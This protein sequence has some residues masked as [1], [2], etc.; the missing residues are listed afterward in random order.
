MNLF[1]RA[2]GRSSAPYSQVTG[3]IK[4]SV[5]TLAALVFWIKLD[6]R[7]LTIAKGKDVDTENGKALANAVVRVL[8]LTLHDGG[9]DLGHDHPGSSCKQHFSSTEAVGKEWN[10]KRAGEESTGS[11]DCS[12]RKDS[13]ALSSQGF[14]EG[15]WQ[16]VSKVV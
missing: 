5:K 8:K 13:L 15:C 6:R 2:T 12:Q 16:L 14:V 11:P 1:R 3:L 4:A 9:V 10:G 7:R